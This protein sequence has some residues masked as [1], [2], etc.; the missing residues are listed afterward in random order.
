MR[1]KTFEQLQV[2]QVFSLGSRTITE[3]DI[4]NFAGVSG[5][6]NPL[7]L[8]EEYAKQTEFGTRIGHGMLSASVATGLCNRSGLF[9]GTL[10]ALLEMSFRFKVPVRPQDTIGLKLVCQ[11]LRLSSKGQRG[12]AIF[13]G[14]LENQKQQ[15]V[16]DSTWTVLLKSSI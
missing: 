12:I 4:V 3:A 13:R 8:S 1:G 5:D 16:M 7:H 2:G 6:F 11:K 9:E 10:I 15:L 14:D